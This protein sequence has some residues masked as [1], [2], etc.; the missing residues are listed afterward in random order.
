[1]AGDGLFRL[2]QGQAQHPVFMLG[3]DLALIDDLGQ[4]ELSME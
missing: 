4:I 1:L 3:F 2:G